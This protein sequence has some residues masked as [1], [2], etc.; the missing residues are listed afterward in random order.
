MSMRHALLCHSFG[1]S[2]LIDSNSQVEDLQCLK[3]HFTL[4]FNSKY[5]LA[6]YGQNLANITMQVHGRGIDL[7]YKP[8]A[9]HFESAMQRVAWDA[10]SFQSPRGCSSVTTGVPPLYQVIL[11]P[12]LNMSQGA[13]RLVDLLYEIG[14]PGTETTVYAAPGQRQAMEAVRKSRREIVPNVRRR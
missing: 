12:N 13:S 2:C 14:G 10:I 3:M 8:E 6:E 9:R 7:E 4:D 5:M 11:T 1:S